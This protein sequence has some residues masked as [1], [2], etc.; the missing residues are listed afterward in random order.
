MTENIFLLIA[1]LAGLGAFISMLV[2]V[3]K[4]IGVVKEN[5]GEVWFQSIS[6][7]VFIAVTIV[8][9]WGIPIN[10][11]E[12]DSWLVLLTTILGF[13]F[14]ILAGRLTHSVIRGTPIIGYSFGK[15]EERSQDNYLQD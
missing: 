14:E 10:W 5:Q 15:E 6:L 12:V 1:G 2:N 13:V 9:L 7:V 8:Y 3:L 4:I 11:G